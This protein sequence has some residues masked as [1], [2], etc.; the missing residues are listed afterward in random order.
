MPELRR[1]IMR[2]LPDAAN[3]GDFIS[4]PALYQRLQ[5]L[6]A[7]PP[8]IKTVGRRLQ[9]LEDEGLVES[10]RDGTASTWRRKA[11]ASG[12]AAKAG[13]MTFDEALALQTLKRFSSRQIPELVAESLSSMFE[14][15]EARLSRTNTANEAK[16]A[17]W[18]SKVAVESGGFA[19]RCPAIDPAMF[20]AASRALFEEHKLSVVYRPRSDDHKE[21]ARVLMPLGIVEVGTLVY[22]IAATDGKED[23]TRNRSGTALRP[24]MY[25][26][27]RFASIEPKPE[28]FDYPPEFSLDA[29]VKEDRHFDFQEG[30]DV[31]LELR[32]THGRG[33][34]LLEARLAADQAAEMQGD[35]LIVRGTVPLSQRLRWWLRAFGPYVEVLAPASLRDELA[36]E[37]H[38]LARL[39]G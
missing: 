19:L 23:G 20:A 2:L 11:G 16:Y 24:I 14:L 37:A 1:Q 39:Y 12:M 9:K 8:T 32:F 27:D 34:H 38:A 4:T 3:S 25:R 35:A 21:K 13:S 33:D 18:A 28:R 10:R 5:R 31:R 15:A 6:F 26:M 7:E 22:L 17:R 30:E 36:A 29:Y